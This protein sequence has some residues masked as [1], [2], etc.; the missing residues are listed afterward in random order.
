M[1]DNTPNTPQIELETAQ[2]QGC[3][4]WAFKKAVEKISTACKAALL[5]LAIYSAPAIS[6][7]QSMAED[8]KNPNQNEAD[9]V[10]V[11]SS[12]ANNNSSSSFTP[13]MQKELYELNWK[14]FKELWVE[15]R[16]RKKEL[17][18]F[19]LDSKNDTIE[20][21]KQETAQNEVVIEKDSETLE[22]LAGIKDALP[23]EIRENYQ[24]ISRLLDK[25]D[26]L[27]QVK[28]LDGKKL[29]E[30][31]E[32]R[33]KLLDEIMI[34]IK[35]NA[36]ELITDLTAYDQEHWTN[37]LAEFTAVVIEIKPSLREVFEIAQTKVL[38]E[39]FRN[40]H[41]KSA[42]WVNSLDWVSIS[43][44]VITK[45][46]NWFKI[47]AW[48]NWRKL[49]LAWNDFQLDSSIDN[50]DEQRQ[51]Q[52]IETE[53]EDEISPINETQNSISS[54][55]KYI[56]EAILKWTSL[57]EVKKNIKLLNLNYYKELG[58]ESASS[59]QDI[60]QALAWFYRKTEEEKQRIVR[61]KKEEVTKI[62]AIVRKKAS[63]KNLETKE[64][65]KIIEAFWIDKIWQHVIEDFLD[66]FNTSSTVLRLP[67][68]RVVSQLS[69]SPFKIEWSGLSSWED[70]W[71]ENAKNRELLAMLINTSISW[72]P[73]YPINT[74]SIDWAILAPTFIKENREEISKSQL[75]DYI[76][77]KLWVNRGA[78]PSVKM[79]E[80]IEANNKNTNK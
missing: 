70:D 65:L 78:N 11:A 44:G 8:G 5:A 63:E 36:Q 38:K 77:E 32:E 61:I 15:G 14:S 60:K 29:D 28:W 54:V 49:S 50:A 16:K 43:Q 23:K 26:E 71:I 3:E 4:K 47:Q 62:L 51:I 69:L 25:V 53:L 58:I 1:A 74:N 12:E 40:F 24:E 80:N 66:R 6:S 18:G 45:E 30:N 73:E 76:N 59:L 37:K 20:E 7:T 35:E 31:H 64:T 34:E 27:T 21:E 67:D 52:E 17:T 41:R 9:T 68:W 39:E 48:W 56:D 72:N 79:M 19:L 2:N 22:K 57:D 75:Q 33:K 55:M 46:E 10:T 13:Q 42:L